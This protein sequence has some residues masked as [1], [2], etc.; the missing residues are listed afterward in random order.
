MVYSACMKAA[1]LASQN[2]RHCMPC[3]ARAG[4]TTPGAWLRPASG[5]VFF[6]HV[7][8]ERLD[9]LSFISEM[10]Y[11]SKIE[12]SHDSPLNARLSEVAFLKILVAVKELSPQHAS[13]RWWCLHVGRGWPYHRTHNDKEQGAH[14]MNASQR[15]GMPTL[16]FPTILEMQSPEAGMRS[17]ELRIT[18]PSRQPI[19]C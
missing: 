15:N 14:T 12:Q 6:I 8:R 19:G 5:R 3:E 16:N 7:V 17:D 2:N 4:E 18:A 13:T 11:M 9:R 1:Y 10:C